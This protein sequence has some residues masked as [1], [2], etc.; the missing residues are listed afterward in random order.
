MAKY[1][2]K[3]VLQ[4]S[5]HEPILLTT[6]LVKVN[7]GEYSLASVVERLMKKTMISGEI[8]NFD[9]KKV[10]YKRPSVFNNRPS[11]AYRIN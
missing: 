10:I 2:S 11:S 4:M 8:L 5:F 3:I 1:V 6:Y 9:K 7:T